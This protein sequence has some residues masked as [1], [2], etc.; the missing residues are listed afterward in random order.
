MGGRSTEDTVAPVFWPWMQVLRDIARERPALREAAQGL[1][2]R[3]GAR[4]PSP[5][6]TDLQLAPGS[7][8]LF[9]GV[10]SLLRDAAREGPVLLL[11]EDLHWADLGSIQLL[12]FICPEL[13]EHATL[14]V[15][16]QRDGRSADRPRELRR[17]SRHAAARIELEPLTPDE[18]GQYV[19]LVAQT[20]AV[21]AELS[22]ILHRA[23]AG[24][25]LFLLQTVRGLVARHG[26]DKLGSLAPELI[27]PAKSARDVLRSGLDTLD[28][29]A[30]RVLEVA[31]VLG[32]YFELST[33]QEL[34]GLEADELLAA[35]EAASEEG[36]VLAEQPHEFRFR[37][38]LLRAALYDDLAAS[39][40]ANQHRRAAKCSSA[41]PTTGQR[42]GEIAHHYYRSL[43]LGDYGRVAAAA[44]Q[45][46]HGGGPAAGI[47]GR[48]EVLPAGRSK[49]RRS[50]SR[51]SPAHAPSCCG[52][53]R[54]SSSSQATGR[55]H[56]AH[57]VARRHRPQARLYRSVL[58]AARIVRPTH[59]MGAR[60][61]PQV[62][63]SSKT[64]CA[65]CRRTRMGCASKR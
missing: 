24:N 55:T 41:P 57:R 58:D 4:D 19:G 44:E 6:V 60:A 52:C 34:C 26:L 36:F 35:L 30:R 11:L 62:C 64:R 43:V 1:L 9:D 17:L 65:P 53:T 27:K 50:I 47:L 8:W 28:E 49:R 61:D 21:D 38:A 51:S 54:N 46:A 33:L 25:P 12:A 39:D 3:L 16:T 32:E 18:V 63:A 2:A 45:A 40:R 23:T 31:S 13:H 7:F 15:T 14:V 42:H 48:G 59:L 22:A 10:S 5:D 37:H 20:G 29:R 56:C